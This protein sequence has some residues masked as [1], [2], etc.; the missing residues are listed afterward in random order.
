MGMRKKEQ[1][2]VERS[3]CLHGTMH[4]VVQL[5]SLLDTGRMYGESVAWRKS[6]TSKLAS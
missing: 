4:M 3:F 1:E 2:V 6:F 5:L